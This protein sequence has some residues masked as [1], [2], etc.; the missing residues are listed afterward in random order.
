M[1]SEAELLRTP[2]LISFWLSPRQTIVRIVA[3]RPRYL[4]VPLA[5]LGGASGAATVLLDM[6][7]GTD[8]VGWR[9]SAG[10]ILGGAVLGFCNLYLFAAVAGWI[11]RTIGGSASTVA[12]RAVYAWS[13]LPIVLGL[14]IVLAV[15]SGLHVFAADGIASPAR[16]PVLQIVQG[17]FGL[18]TLVAALLMLARVEGFGFGRALVTHLIGSL[19]AP[20]LLALGV[21][22]FLYQPFSIPSASSAPTVLP[23]DYIFVAK[24]AYGYTHYSLPFS[25]PLFSGRIFGAEPQRGDVVVFRLPKDD[26]TDYTKRVLGMPGDR[27][28]MKEGQL[29]IN[30]SAV[31]RERIADFSGVDVCGGGTGPVKRWRETLPNGVSY[32][33]LDCVDNGFYDNTNIYT[34][35]AGHFFMIGDNRDNSTDSRVLSSVGYVPFD[36]LIGRVGMIF[37]SRSDGTDGGAAS[38]RYERIGTVVR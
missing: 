29:Y 2:P 23:G 15:L 30:G 6:G 20:A 9:G 24:Y 36:H 14:I 34:V 27:I 22:T 3:E 16:S 17:I 5:V 10:T 4:V 35:P 1:S 12:V 8:L 19:S 37:F 33:T 32:E 7:I 38:V 13:Q 21:R 25:P 31:K 28:Q 26:M 11:G 18:W